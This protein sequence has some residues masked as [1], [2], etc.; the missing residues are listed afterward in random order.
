MTDSLLSDL[1]DGGGTSSSHLRIANPAHSVV[2]VGFRIHADMVTDEMIQ[3]A[4]R[5]TG[6]ALGRVL[7][8][9]A[10]LDERQFPRAYGYFVEL[11]GELGVYDCWPPS[12]RL[13]FL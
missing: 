2:S 12:A 1:S 4:I 3:S 7:E 6:D 8:F 5:S 13:N 9:V 10:E 11:E